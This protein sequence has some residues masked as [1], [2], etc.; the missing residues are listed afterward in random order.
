MRVNPVR[1]R[2]QSLRIALITVIFAMLLPALLAHGAGGANG[3]TLVDSADDLMGTTGDEWSGATYNPTNQS[4]MVIDDESITYQFFL[5]DDGKIDS[6]VAAHIFILQLGSTDHEGISWV[7]DDTYAVLS[8][9]TGHV[10]VVEFPAGSPSMATVVSVNRL[11]RDFYVVPQGEPQFN[12]GPEGIAFDGLDVYVTKEI[13]PR[14]GKFD[15]NGTKQAEVN[16]SG[17]GDATG[18]AVAPDGTFYVTSHE[19]RRVV[20][21]EVDWDAGTATSLGLISLSAMGQVEAIAARDGLA[22][23][24]FGEAEG[25]PYSHFEGT[26]S[27]HDDSNPPGDAN[28]SGGLSMID[29]QLVA[30]VAVDLA[31]ADDYCDPDIN[32]DGSTT[33]L[34]ALLVA[35]CAIDIVNDYCQS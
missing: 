10:Q 35:Q 9:E 29:A 31:D 1:A 15:I 17:I 5:D 33:M 28:C 25:R 7:E 22:L 3:M 20:Q 12:H 19:S 21:Y 11:V 16:L 27:A 24:I 4:L 6:G 30:R 34:D 23:H 2:A 32:G 13:P 8:E 18:V 26:L 14:L